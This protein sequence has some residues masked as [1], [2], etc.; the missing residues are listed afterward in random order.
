MAEHAW[1]PG[2]LRLF[3]THISERKAVASAIANRLRDFQIDA[4]V[5][6]EAIAPTVAWQDEIED[7]L[8]TCDACFA[9]LSPGFRESLWCDQEVGV[10]FGRGVLV[11]AIDDGL[12]PYGFIG[13]FQALS[14]RSDDNYHSLGNATYEL[15]RDNERSGQAMAR[16]LVSRF[17][18]S[19]S[20]AEAVANVDLLHKVPE[21]MWTAELLATVKN[22]NTQN[23]QIAGANYRYGGP[24][25]STV[26]GRLADSILIEDE[27]LEEPQRVAAGDQLRALGL[28][29]SLAGHFQIRDYASPIEM[30]EPASVI[31]IVLG[32]R[33]VADDIVLSTTIKKTFVDALVNCS[34]SEWL[35]EATIER[36]RAE[37]GGNYTLASLAW[38]RTTPNSQSTATARTQGA[39]SIEFPGSTLT[40][41]ATLQ[42]R[43]GLIG[44]VPAVLIIDFT[45]RL[46]DGATSERLHLSLDSLDEL[47]ISMTTSAVD[48]VGATVLPLLVDTP[49]R[50]VGPNIEIQFGDRPVEQILNMPPTF[51]RPEGASGGLGADIRTPDGLDSYDSTERS[52]L[53]RRGITS[54]LRQNGYDN[55]EGWEN[56]VPD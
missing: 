39:L 43:G 42:V 10:C 31:R 26:A 36:S 44:G 19:G 40:A 28:V 8:I 41:R 15:L 12:A 9:L 53:I 54:M 27:R 38:E 11:L 22:A 20:Y 47:L 13:R 18:A 3:L 16:A 29:N 21:A 32:L 5:A 55:V 6:H 34:F 51:E 7:A 17:Q 50:L 46:T 14:P 30:S 1:E 2:H 25:V 4:F 23:R 48:Q 56:A 49:M 35:S 33:E 37:I 52:R 24:K 45:E